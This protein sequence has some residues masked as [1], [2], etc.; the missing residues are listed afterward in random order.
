M[1]MDKNKEVDITKSFPSIKWHDAILMQCIVNY[2]D[3]DTSKEILLRIQWTT[4]EISCICFRNVLWA[5]ISYNGGIFGAE[6]ILSISVKDNCEVLSLVRKRVP[7]LYPDEI[8]RYYE[9]ETIQSAGKIRV[10]ASSV[11]LI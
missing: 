10:I 9:I 1:A 5:E 11:T 7:K 4:H 3:T 2:D 6:N 8:M